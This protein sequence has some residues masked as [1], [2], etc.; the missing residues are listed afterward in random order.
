M[1]CVEGG[2]EVRDG[3][4]AGFV[5][6]MLVGAVAMGILPLFTVPVSVKAEA[7]RAGAARWVADEDGYARFEWIDSREG[8]VR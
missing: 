6:G 1:H 4:L 8:A 5:L 3:A 7:V 2:V